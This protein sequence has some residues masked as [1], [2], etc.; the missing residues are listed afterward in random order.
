MS[1]PGH[2]FRGAATAKNLARFTR[3]PLP[4]KDLVR[5]LLYDPPLIDF[6]QSE[7]LLEDPYLVLRLTESDLQQELLFDGHFHLSG[8]RYS[9]AGKIV[10]EVL[11][12]KLDEQ[13]RFPYTIRINLAAE[14]I[15]T[16]LI[17]S[18]LQ[19]NIEIPQDRFRLKNPGNIPLET[20]P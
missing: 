12:Q 17:F 7:V 18:G 19:T 3:I 16:A 14:K 10:L 5:L 8:C 13:R 9:W 1:V 2:S 11:Y 6:R 15:K 4:A 20:L